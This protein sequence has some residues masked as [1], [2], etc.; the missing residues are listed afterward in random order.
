M[1]HKPPCRTPKDDPAMAGCRSRNTTDHLMRRVRSD[2]LVEHIEEQYKINL[3]VR[4]DM[5]L[6]TALKKFHVPSQTKLVEKFQ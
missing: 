1:S 6:G 5:E 3:G 2:K 4:G